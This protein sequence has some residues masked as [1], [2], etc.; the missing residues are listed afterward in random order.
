MT[1]KRNLFQKNGRFY[2]S[3]ILNILDGMLSGTGF[4]VFFQ[5]LK[6][7]SVN[8]LTK[9][10]IIQY[11]VT[12]AALYI[13]RLIL[14]VTGYTQG[15]Y[16]ASAIT[17]RIRIFLGDKLKRIPLDRLV[18]EKTGHYINIVTSNVNSYENI[19]THKSG[20]IAKG[21]SFLCLVICFMFVLYFPAG[22]IVF[23]TTALII[24][25]VR[26][27]YNKV[28]T[29]GVQK[30]KNQETAT[31]DIIEYTTGI[32]TFRAYGFAGEK[33]RALTSSLKQYSDISY[34]F[35]K[36]TLPS[37]VLYMIIAWCAFPVCLLI[38]GTAWLNGNLPASDFFLIS[39]LPLFT[40]K[41]SGILFIDLTYYRNL[42]ISRNSIFSVVEEKEEPAPNRPFVPKDYS[43]AFDHVNFCYVAGEQILKD[44]SFIAEQGKFMAIVGDSGSGKSTILNLAAKYYIPDQ[45]TV[46]MGG[47]DIREYPSEQIL[48]YISMVDQDTFLFGDTIM[49]NVR[50]AK[51]SA[52]DDEVM[53]ACHQANCDSFVGQLE[54]GYNTAIGE[55]GGQLSGGERQRLSIARAILRNSPILL[56]DEATASLDIENEL[57]VREAISLLLGKGKTVLM[58]AHTLSIIQSA[59]LI[60][61]VEQ[62][63]IVECGSHEQLL[64]MAGKYARMWSAEQKLLLRT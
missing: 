9:V 36:S 13:I 27:A 21:I 45:G 38:G 3:V 41:L 44:V 6:K 54:N 31:S 42:I 1:G 30:N 53:V 23:V 22:L 26:A 37:G 34:Q 11:S 56:L 57:A 62:G 18:R 61:V 33:N 10:A 17:H 28:K 5:I 7:L 16:G 47:T 52:R 39:M 64:M 29:Y 55:N 50:L 48:R 20:D 63:R 60:L 59:D 49:N 43:I 12:L 46:Y 19:L 24:P 35:E 58:I 32:R 15:Q 8:N 14:Y 51:P 4:M 40:G 25:C 2:V